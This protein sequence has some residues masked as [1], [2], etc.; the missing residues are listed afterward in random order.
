[1]RKK[2]RTTAEA[3]LFFILLP[4]ACGSRKGLETT[5]S[6]VRTRCDDLRREAK[7][8]ARIRARWMVAGWARRWLR[9]QGKYNAGTGFAPNTVWELIRALK[10]HDPHAEVLAGDQNSGFAGVVIA[11]GASPAEPNAIALVPA[12]FA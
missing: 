6:E 10:K 2:M 8:S 11:P 5:L 4:A 12:R 3:L 9:S 1:M 7:Q